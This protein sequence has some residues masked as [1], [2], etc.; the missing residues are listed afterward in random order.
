MYQ[1]TMLNFEGNKDIYFPVFVNWN[2]YINNYN[3]NKA[4]EFSRL[5]TCYLCHNVLDFQKGTFKEFLQ[6]TDDGHICKA[7]PL[8]IRNSIRLVSDNKDE[9]LF[10]AKVS[11][12]TKIRKTLSER[13]NDKEQS[14]P[15][16]RN[17]P[18]AQKGTKELEH[19]FYI[20][21]YSKQVS[22]WDLE[23]RF[24]QLSCISLI[25]AVRISNF[26]LYFVKII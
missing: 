19:E 2:E 5:H 18:E 21:V 4:Y 20:E 24:K 17:S 13:T 7:P 8:Q 1:K 25:C 23:I 9:K 26:H 14:S 10:S 16:G 12:D 22:I 3:T 11:V 15:N 6:Y